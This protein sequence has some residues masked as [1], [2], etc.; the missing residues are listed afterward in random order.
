MGDRENAVRRARLPP[1]VHRT[2]FTLLLCSPVVK[3]LSRHGLTTGQPYS[4]AS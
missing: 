2:R 3:R 4:A 1:S